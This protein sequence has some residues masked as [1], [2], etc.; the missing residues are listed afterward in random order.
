MKATLGHDHPVTLGAIA[1][2]TVDIRLIGKRNAIM[3]KRQLLPVMRASF[4]EFH[5]TTLTIK[6]KLARSYLRKGSLNEVKTHWEEALRGMIRING[7]SHPDISKEKH[8]LSDVERAIILKKVCLFWMPEQFFRYTTA[9]E[10]MSIAKVALEL[11]RILIH[12][13]LRHM[14]LTSHMGRFLRTWKN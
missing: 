12:E 8:L 2:S 1:D 14:C 9:T 4:G 13:Y 5:A 11:F 6:S 10:Y 3:A 7:N